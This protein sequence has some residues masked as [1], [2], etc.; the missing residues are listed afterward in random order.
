VTPSAAAIGRRHAMPKLR[1]ALVAAQLTGLAWM[2]YVLCNEPLASAS[3]AMI[4]K[5]FGPSLDAT[6]GS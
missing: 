1:A 5:T 3:P 2:R 4:A 6:L